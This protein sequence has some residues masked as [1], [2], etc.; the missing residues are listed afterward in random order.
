MFGHLR[1]AGYSCDD[2][3]PETLAAVIDDVKNEI[4]DDDSNR[5]Q[6]PPC[7]KNEEKKENTQEIKFSMSKVPLFIYFNFNS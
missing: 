1:E 3:S 2:I 5:E 4:E 7:H 6:S